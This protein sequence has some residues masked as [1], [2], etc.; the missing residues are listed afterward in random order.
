MTDKR[1]VSHYEAIETLK[2]GSA[3]RFR[4]IRPDDKAR[5]VEAFRNLEPESIYTRFFH[6]KKM[7]TDEE[8]K[9]ATE[10]DF[11][12]VVGLVV[13]VGAGAQETII[14]AARYAVLDATDPRPSAEVAFTVEED[15][16]GQGIAHLLLKH[17]TA[18]ARG[19]GITHFVAEVLAENRAMQTVFAH[20]G[21][22]M[23]KAYEDGAVHV[24]LQLSAGGE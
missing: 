13:T 1:D 3:A 9:A 2:S 8:L 15:Y 6:H 10:V 19:R 5:L 23:Q 12:A 17:L 4:A 16:Q 21:L 22:P 7:L 11:D 18:I 20:S 24:T 14:G